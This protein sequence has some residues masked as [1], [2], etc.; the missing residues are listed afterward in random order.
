MFLYDSITHTNNYHYY[1]GY[2]LKALIFTHI[3]LEF[4]LNLDK[5]TIFLLKTCLPDF[6][7]FD[8]ILFEIITAL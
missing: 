5:H 6:H 8:I 2:S 3:G 1:L 4:N 7:L